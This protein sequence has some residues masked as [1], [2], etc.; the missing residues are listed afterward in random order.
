MIEQVL[1]D[2]LL[3]HRRLLVDDVLVEDEG[4]VHCVF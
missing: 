4:V 1:G 3:H 2:L